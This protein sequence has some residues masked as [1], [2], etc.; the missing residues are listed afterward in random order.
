MLSLPIETWV[1]FFIWLVI[2]L[3]IYFLYSVSHSRLGRGLT[4][5]TPSAI[6]VSGA[7]TSRGS[8][9]L[10]GATAT[11]E[12]I[13]VTLGTSLLRAAGHTAARDQLRGTDRA[14]S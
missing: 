12:I 5:A 6:S 9:R 2:G 4:P 8:R 13:R 1:R 14:L 3:V 10:A 7:L 11:S